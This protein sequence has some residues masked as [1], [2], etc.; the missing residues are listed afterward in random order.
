[1]SRTDMSGGHCLRQNIQTHNLQKKKRKE[2]KNI[3]ISTLNK[4]N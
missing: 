3:V 1:M 2:N 4:P